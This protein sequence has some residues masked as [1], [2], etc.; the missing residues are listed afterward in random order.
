MTIETELK[1]V[2]K[3]AAEID[4]SALLQP[5]DATH[6]PAVK[7]SN[8]YFDTDDNQLRQ[9]DMGL[10]IRGENQ[11]YEMTLKTSGT[12]LGGLHQR[13]E[14]NIS[15]SKPLLDLSL[16]PDSL[17]PEGTDIVSLQQRL[18]ELFS[19]DFQRETWRV[20]V[21]DSEVEIAL[22]RGELKAAGQTQPI[23]ELE[24]E[25]KQG[26][27]E[28]IFTLARHLI[29]QGGGVFR[30]GYLSKAARG[31][32]LLQQCA[33]VAF[34]P[35]GV[36]SIA[37]KSHCE[38]GLVQ[39]L[40]YLLQEW[41]YHES[42]SAEPDTAALHEIVR[43]IK[44]T[45][46]V[47]LLFSGLIP[48]KASHQLRLDLQSLP[49]LIFNSPKGEAL[50][51]PD[52]VATQ[53]ALTHWIVTQTWVSDLNDKQR[54]KM[55][56]SYKRWS[57]QMADRLFAEIKKIASQSLASPNDNTLRQVLSNKLQLLQVISGCYPCSPVLSWFTRWQPV[58]ADPASC[59]GRQAIQAIKDALKQPPFWLTSYP[60][61]DQA[62][63]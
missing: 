16:L 24:L 55:A 39:I 29:A 43:D 54:N 1:F 58:M 26:Q 56:S 34:R 52:Y 5:F 12:T 38:A 27:Q 63:H 33:V 19:T 46:Q 28:A 61:K 60:N 3:S 17:W 47:L 50:F 57:D 42:V 11:Q 20:M 8:C 25:L 59:Q 45:N 41:Q 53:L 21:G 48:R 35:L 30:L 37:P 49:S 14:Y 36:P 32:A 18:V 2:I 23:Y 7:L 6:T 22:D 31:H 51:H 9:W 10:R 13:P 4:I 62:H 15:L 40:S 44:V